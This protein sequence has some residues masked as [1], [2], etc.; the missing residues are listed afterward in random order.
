MSHVYCCYSFFGFLA[1]D[2]DDDGDHQNRYYRRV[3][4]RMR[5]SLT[6]LSDPRTSERLAS[7]MEVQSHIAHEDLGSGQFNYSA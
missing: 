7:S 4:K 3:G 2:D 6:F 5:R 1:E